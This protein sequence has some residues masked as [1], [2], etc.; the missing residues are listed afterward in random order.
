MGQRGLINILVGVGRHSDV[1]RDKGFCSLG[2]KGRRSMNS[3]MFEMFG[4][5]SE[6]KGCIARG[7]W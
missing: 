6:A 5:F 3:R 1:G 2:P 4:T 7:E